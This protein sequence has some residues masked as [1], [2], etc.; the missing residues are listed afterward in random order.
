MVVVFPIT[1]HLIHIWPPQKLDRTCK[2][3]VNY[4]KINQVVAATVA[5]VPNV[6][7]LLK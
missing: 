5:V 4:H 6:L 3:R 7:S 1:F 2:M